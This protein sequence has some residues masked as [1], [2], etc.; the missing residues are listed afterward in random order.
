MSVNISIS[1]DAASLLRRNDFTGRLFWLIAR[2]LFTGKI[3]LDYLLYEIAW[4]IQVPPNSLG[5]AGSNA[6]H[7]SFGCGL[8]PFR[9]I[10]D[11]TKFREIPTSWIVIPFRF[12]KRILRARTVF[13][14]E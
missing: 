1:N 2:R 11:P 14:D 10:H 5:R 13:F 12:V 6:E 8:L 9:T 4:I 7:H 3:N